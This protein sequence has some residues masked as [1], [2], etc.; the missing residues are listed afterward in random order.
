M[1]RKMAYYSTGGLPILIITLIL[2]HILVIL[3]TLY[4]HGTLDLSLHLSL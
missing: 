2:V 3:P 1:T 4:N